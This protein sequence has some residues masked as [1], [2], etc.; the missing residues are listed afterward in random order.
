MQTP[1]LNPY[2]EVSRGV[3]Y[4]SLHQHIGAA[5]ALARM[6]IRAGSPESSL[7]KNVICIKSS[8]V[9]WHRPYNIN[10]S[11]VIFSMPRLRVSCPDVIFSLRLYLELSSAHLASTCGYESFAA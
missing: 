11:K 1:P 2:T 6:R 8:F 5:K 10:I 4:L 9:S 3:S 7:I